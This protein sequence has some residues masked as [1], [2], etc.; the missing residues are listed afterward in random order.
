MASA[1]VP[2][3]F[4]SHSFRIEAATVAAY[5]EV[6]NHLIQSMDCWS[7]NASQLYIRMPAEVLA[8][9]SKSW[10]D[11]VLGV[12]AVLSYHSSLVPIALCPCDSSLGLASFS[13]YVLL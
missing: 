1:N 12:P 5:N 10:P 9:L 6:P 8:A 11:E 7:S 2:R 13:K 4:S 3:N